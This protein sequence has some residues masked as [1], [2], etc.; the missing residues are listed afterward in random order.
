MFNGHLNL[1]LE[2]VLSR[3]ECTDRHKHMLREAGEYW[4]KRI[5]NLKNLSEFCK[6]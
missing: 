3:S 1:P 4:S 6:I 5:H 2:K